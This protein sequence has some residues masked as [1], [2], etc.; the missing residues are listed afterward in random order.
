VRAQVDRRDRAVRNFVHPS[1]IA[2]RDAAATAQPPEAVLRDL[3]SD[4]FARIEETIAMVAAMLAA[5]SQ[6]SAIVHDLPLEDTSMAA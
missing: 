5:V 1:L 6:A 2:L 3:V 4:Q